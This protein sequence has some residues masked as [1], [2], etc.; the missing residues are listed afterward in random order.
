MSYHVVFQVT[1]LERDALEVLCLV[2]SVKNLF[3]PINRI[4]PEILSL[5]PGHCDDNEGDIDQDLITL[6]H[7]CR[8]WRDMFTSRSLLWTRLDFI[9]VEKAHTYIQRSQSS[10]LDIR[11]K[12][13]SYLDDAFSLAIPHLRRLKSLTICVDVLPDILTHFRC[14][15]PLL[16]EL[17]IALYQ[18]RNPILDN[19]L[20]GGDLSSLRKLTLEGDITI[21]HLPWNNMTNLQVLNLR[22]RSA[23]HITQFLDFFETTPLLHAVELMD[24]IPDSSDAPPQRIVPLPHL[25]ALTI[26][27][28][29]PPSVLLNHLCIPTGASL[30]LSFNFRGEK[31]PLLDYLPEASPNIRNLSHITTVNLYFSS[32]EKL[33]RLSGPSGSLRALARL[34][35]R[36]TNS[37]TINRRILRSLTP[38]ILSTTQRLAVS[39]Y[40]YPETGESLVFRTLSSMNNLR[41]LTLTNCD[42]LT[43]ILALNPEETPSKPMPCPNLDELVLYI[44]LW[45]QLHVDHLTSMAKNRALG[46]AKLSSITI[47]GP[48]PGRP[49]FELR[50]YVT[51]VKYRV[52]KAALDSF[53]GKGSDESSD[54]SNESING[55]VGESVDESSNESSDESV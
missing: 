7:V 54:W 25:K 8:G 47:V 45:S 50:E 6:T 2:R 1:A 35:R 19:T 32:W 39:K 28:D 37:S 4:P 26:N 10:P 17:N 43:F 9:N 30:N 33:V 24:S 51:D 12:Y 31:S 22:S 16:E 52:D 36:K 38:S 27:A 15:A 21:T 34:T 23:G 5:I 42:N 40:R 41:S 3:A 53:L 49:M 46:G 13:T 20:F 14:Q 18:N 29:P 55:S 48:A 44:R 11:L